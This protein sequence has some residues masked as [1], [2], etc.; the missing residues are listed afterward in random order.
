MTLKVPSF[1]QKWARF[2]VISR[3]GLLSLNY[4]CEVQPQ[5]FSWLS[6]QD[7]EIS[8]TNW[9]YLANRGHITKRDNFV[10]SLAAVLLFVIIKIKN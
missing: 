2:T 9:F 10:V 1:S 3:D 6:P 8:Y 4:N 5:Q 7:L